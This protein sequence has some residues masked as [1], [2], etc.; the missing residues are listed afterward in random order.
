MAGKCSILNIAGRNFTCR[1]VAHVHNVQGVRRALIWKLSSSLTLRHVPGALKLGSFCQNSHVLIKMV[2][3]PARDYTEN[4]IARL[5]RHRKDIRR[6][7]IS[8]QGSENWVVGY[9]LKFCDFPTTERTWWTQRP[10]FW[11]SR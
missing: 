11:I 6:G 10:N 2:V 3:Y 7:T 4:K 5:D 8:L 9:M 1:T